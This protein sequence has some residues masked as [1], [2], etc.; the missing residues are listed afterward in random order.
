MKTTN[1]VAS[2]RSRRRAEPD[3]AEVGQ[4][5]RARAAQRRGHE[6]QQRQVAGGEADR[7]PEHVDA[8]LE[9]QAGDAEEGRRGQVFA[10]DRGRVPGRADRPGG[11]QEVRG[12]AGQR[13]P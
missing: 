9:D 11:D 4:G 10:A 5:E 7:V 8:V 13:R 2:L 3:L 12:G 6:Q 1:T